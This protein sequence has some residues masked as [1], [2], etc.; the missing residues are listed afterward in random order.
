MS[1]RPIKIL[2]VV[3]NLA[4]GGAER[5]VSTLLPRLDPTRFVPSV[6]CLGWDGELFADVR[7]SGIEARALW[8]TKR[9]AARALRELVSIMRSDLPDVVVVMGRNAEIIGRIAARVAGVARTI[10]WVHQA[11]EILPR[12]TGH[13]M[14]DRALRRWTNRYFGVAEAQRRFL[15]DERGYPV[16]KIRIIRNGVDPTLFDVTTCRDSLGE[17]G[18]TE[19]DP[20][21]G[22]I[23]MLRWEK[24]H[25]TFL[26][27]ARI[28]LDQLP[29]AKFLVVGDGPCR[30]GLEA[31]CSDLDLSGSVC[32]TGIRGD[33]DRIL[34]AVDVFA[35]TSTTECFPMALLEAMAC[36]RPV[37]CT[38]VGGIVEIVN[39][40]ETGYLVSPR[41]PEQ[42]AA[43]M[44]QL[45]SDPEAARRMG[46]AGRRRVE[47]EF[48][49]DRSVE[50]AQRAIEDLITVR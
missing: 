42:V 49:L 37:V 18:V 32:F 5:H 45:L 9:Q 46:L 43:R 7:D 10:V 41:S 48:G 19:G 23:G 36:A 26:R 25:E 31:L 17:F 28:V 1:A 30:S 47:A 40:G 29:R 2:F 22:I 24:D 8:L 35:M 6:V 15:A 3:P 27:A 39:D 11:T 44:V 34:C 13:R 4:A 21:V 16:E 14:I 12:G 38:A 20:V 50:A 33:I